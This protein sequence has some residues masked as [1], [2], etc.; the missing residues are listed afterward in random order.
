MKDALDVV[1][2]WQLRN[3]A[4]TNPEDAIEEVKNHRAAN[5]ELTFDLIRHFLKL[6]IRPLFL[7]PANNNPSGVTP[8]GRKL[9]NAPLPRKLGMQ[10]METPAWKNAKE[11][12]ALD[13]LQWV[14]KSLGPK[15]VVEVWPMLIPPVL[16]LVDDWETRYKATGAELLGE[17][18]KV[19]EPELLER[20]GLGEVFE[21]ALMPCL[22]YLPPSTPEEEAVRLLGAVYPA[23]IALT[24]VRYPVGSSSGKVEPKDMASQRA[25]FLDK[26]L[27]DGIIYGISNCHNHPNTLII[28]C[29]HLAIFLDEMG[30]EAVKHIKYVLP[31][32]TGV[33]SHPLGKASLPMLHQATV[34]LQALIRN[35]WP[36]MVEY[37][38]EVLKGIT[39]CWLGV[40][41]EPAAESLRTSLKGTAA[42]LR[43]A[44]KEEYDLR[45]DY[46]M[47]IQAD[48]R[49]GGLLL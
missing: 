28:T 24:R 9:A 36:R 31:F 20:T 4:A 40:E 13:I 11:A 2:A 18:L 22:A 47:L 34:A 7:K 29:E 17:L 46:D 33:L 49:L 27:R 39:L 32:L 37:R 5:G 1:M 25:K 19:V 23:L 35:C 21:D 12:H 43:E 26:V 6:T 48:A 38:G 8:Q 44:I 42:L 10:A 3:P 30:I 16:T 15:S 41:G 45:Q 14:V